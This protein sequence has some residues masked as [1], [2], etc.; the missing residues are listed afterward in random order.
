MKKT[1]ILVLVMSLL[2]LF[3][4]LFNEASGR[5]GGSPSTRQPAKQPVD[6][7]VRDDTIELVNG[8]LLTGKI[9]DISQGVVRFDGQMIAGASSV[10]L[11]N[12]RRIFFPKP[13]GEGSKPEADQLIFPNGDRLSINIKSM[14]DKIIEGTTLTGDP[15]RLEKGKVSGLFFKKVPMKILEEHFDSDE[16]GFTPVKGEWAVEEGQFV[17]KN[18]SSSSYRASALLRQQGR[19]N[20]KWTVDTSRSDVTGFYFFARDGTSVHGG[21]SYYLTLNGT[22]SVYLYKCQN[23]NQ[24]YYA[25]Y[26]LSKGVEHVNF[27]LEYDPGTGLIAIKIN[28]EEA[29]RW[30]DTEPIQKG[31]YI[32][33]HANGRAAF[34]NVIVSHIG[35]S[36]LPSLA[37]ASPDEDVILFVNGDIL[38]GSVVSVDGENVAIE[39][40]YD[41]EGIV[42]SKTKISSLR[43]RMEKGEGLLSPPRSYKWVMWNGDTLTGRLD[44]LDDKEIKIKSDSAGDLILPRRFLKR[45]ETP[46]EM[47]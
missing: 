28:G 20:Y 31:K 33:L 2:A 16:S 43:F 44:Y 34:D 14:D 22:K 30:K 39:D 45:I 9:A 38:S 41:P 10:P 46:A 23:N 40:E 19:Y 35:D 13:E 6:R 42:I 36:F 37:A 3:G 7:V 25:S 27:E 17:Q 18:K 21:N 29:M 26:T 47:Y 32:I 24:H 8:D 4:T 5:N 15:L 11:R 12:I 1:A